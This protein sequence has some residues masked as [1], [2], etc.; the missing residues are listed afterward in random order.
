MWTEIPILSKLRDIVQKLTSSEYTYCVVQY[1]PSGKV[2]INPHKD[3]EMIPGSTICGLSV[4]QNRT[5]RMSRNGKNIDL[6]LLSG[7]LYVLYPPT[8]DY[9]THSILKDDSIHPRISLTFRTLI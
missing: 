5:L 6:D 4:G 1:Y 3:K 9:W 7:S 2:G 8:N